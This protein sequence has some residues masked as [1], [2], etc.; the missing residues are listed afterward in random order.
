MITSIGIGTAQTVPVPDVFHLQFDNQSSLGESTSLA[1]DIINNHDGTIS[2][3][4]EYTIGVSGNASDLTNVIPSYITIADHDDLSQGTGIGDDTSYSISFSI[5]CDDYENILIFEKADEYKL[6]TVDNKLVYT[7]Y[8][9]FWSGI[10]EK[11]SSLDLSR[12]NNGGYISIILTGRYPTGISQIYVNNVAT[13]SGYN[14]P[15]ITYDGM[16]NTPSDLII[17][18]LTTDH[19][20][21][22]DEFQF[23]NFHLDDRDVEYL[24]Y[25]YYD[26]VPRKM[27]S[28]W[29]LIKDVVDNMSALIDLIVFFII[30]TVVMSVGSFVI[31]IIKKK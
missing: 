15:G 27:P 10:H 16:R 26:G 11:K 17:G 19:N 20:M 28:I 12:Y 30:V 6:E 4:D 2:N 23:F 7:Q 25:S 9:S 14:P 22:I 24:Y 8:D 13:I 1:V 3:M 21:C 31:G 29:E 5:R 18:D